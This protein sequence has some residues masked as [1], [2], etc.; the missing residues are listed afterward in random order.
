MSIVL[1]L[2]DGSFAWYVVGGAAAADDD[3]D[4]DEGAPQQQQY[5]DYEVGSADYYRHMGQ[6]DWHAHQGTGMGQMD[7][8]RATTD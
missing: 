8:W 4:D 2:G 6:G 5:G 3:E 7:T 1:E